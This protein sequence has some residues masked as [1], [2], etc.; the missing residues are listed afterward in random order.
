[1]TTK[2]GWRICPYCHTTLRHNCSNCQNLIN[3]EWDICPYC[4]APQEPFKP[5]RQQR[6]RLQPQPVPATQFAPVV[7]GGSLRLQSSNPPLQ[8]GHG[9]TARL[10]ELE[11]DNSET[12]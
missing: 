4:A 9:K 5:G 11:E 8:N 10:P 12:V 3:V 2:E 7:N 1:R 6:T